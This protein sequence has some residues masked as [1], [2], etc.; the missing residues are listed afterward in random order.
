MRPVTQAEVDAGWSAM[1]TWNVNI[2]GEDLINGSPKLGDMVARNPKNHDD[3]WL[4]AKSYFE[5]NLAIISSPEATLAKSAKHMSFS[6]ALHYLKEGYKV[7]R[8]GWNGKGMYI[9]LI[10]SKESA[11]LTEVFT[12]VILESNDGPNE[13]SAHKNYVDSYLCMKTA[14]GT[15]QPGW[16][17]SQ[18]D[19]LSEDWE[20][21]YI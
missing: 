9:A 3:Q 11:E 17:A 8:K 4:V 12:D 14:S 19:M 20:I 13:C 1:Q 21:I 16:L 6:Q 7:A 2:S 15:V 5:E 10:P 18:A